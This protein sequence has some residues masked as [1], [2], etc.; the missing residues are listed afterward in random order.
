MKCYFMA[1]IRIHDKEEY[2]KYLEGIDEVFARY[3]GKYLAVDTHPVL[4]EGEWGPGRAVLIE[5]PSETELHRWYDSEDYRRLLQH[6]LNSAQCN[7]I[8]IRGLE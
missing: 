1:Q 8:M 3:N 5:F 2:T 6:R 4:L 7:T